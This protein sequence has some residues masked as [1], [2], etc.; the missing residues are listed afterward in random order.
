MRS[1][2]ADN[3]VTQAA[4]LGEVDGNGAV[5]SRLVEATADVVDTLLDRPAALQGAIRRFGSLLGADGWPLETVA[6]WFAALQPHV[7]RKHRATLRSHA[8]VTVLAAGW[9][10]SFVR[11]A[12]SDQCIDPVT[13]LG[14]ALVLRLRLVEVYQQCRAL[15]VD[16]EDRYRLVVIDADADNLPPFERDAVMV[17]IAGICTE[18]FHSGETIVRC[19]SRIVVLAAV[20]EGS[21][22]REAVVV[23]RLLFAP[24][25]RAAH[26]IVWNDRLPSSMN[27]ID[28]YLRELV[29]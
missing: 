3:E 11:G 8:S 24:I 6:N 5:D 9:A 22:G 27:D 2:R 23:D 29:S 17:T 18:V 1:R 7:P 19:G 26:P 25:A 14:T 28:S 16:I 4:W 10:E 20:S 15:D 13:A 12:G 21:E